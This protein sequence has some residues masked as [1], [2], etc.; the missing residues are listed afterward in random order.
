MLWSEG[1]LVGACRVLEEEPQRRERAALTPSQGEVD[2]AGQ[3]ETVKRSE[4]GMVTDPVTCSPDNTL[5]EVDAMCARF[6]IS[7]L[8]AILCPMLLSSS[9]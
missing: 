6:R 9:A 2:Q 1:V 4:A 8:V 5:A 7:G 3:V